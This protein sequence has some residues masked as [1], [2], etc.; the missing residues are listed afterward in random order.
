MLAMCIAL[1]VCG[2]K[3]GR[4]A[5]EERGANPQSWSGLQGRLTWEEAVH[6]CGQLGLELPSSEDFKA[7]EKSD[8]YASWE[9]GAYWSG[10]TAPGSEDRALTFLVTDLLGVASG[11]LDRSGQTKQDRLFVRCIQAVR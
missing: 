6:R 9:R 5:E 2:C 1:L 10:S 7:A 8:A 11:G 3:P 4:A